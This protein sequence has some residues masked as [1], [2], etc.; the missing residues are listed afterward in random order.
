VCPRSVLHRAGQR[1]TCVCPQDQS[2]GVRRKSSADSAGGI[3][4]ACFH[5]QSTLMAVVAVLE[6]L[7]PFIEGALGAVWMCC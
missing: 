4:R 3:G 1:P 2:R 7:G 5:C 6:G